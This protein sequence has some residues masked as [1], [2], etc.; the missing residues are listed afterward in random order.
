MKP[1]C[2]HKD[3]DQDDERGCGL[4]DIRSELVTGVGDAADI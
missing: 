4:G 2:A 1:Q 3:Q